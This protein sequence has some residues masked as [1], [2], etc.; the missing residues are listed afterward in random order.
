MNGLL[1]LRIIITHPYSE[2]NL[3]YFRRLVFGNLGGIEQTEL[4]YLA[5]VRA[6]PD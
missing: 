5:F 4:N 3:W 2:V 6:G 1:E